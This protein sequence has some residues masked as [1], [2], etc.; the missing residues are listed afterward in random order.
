MF[1]F[2]NRMSAYNTYLLMEEEVLEMAPTHNRAA[3]S[4]WVSTCQIEV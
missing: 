3:D 2:A 1:D 4:T